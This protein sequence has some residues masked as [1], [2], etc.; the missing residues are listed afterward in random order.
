MTKELGFSYDRP[1]RT[2][3]KR[4]NRLMSYAFDALLPLIL[5]CVAYMVSRFYFLQ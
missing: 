3:M 1:A 5:V 4:R 2:E